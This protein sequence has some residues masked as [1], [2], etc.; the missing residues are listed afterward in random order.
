MTLGL[1]YALLGAVLGLIAGSA[2]NAFVWRLH[3]GKSWVHGR[4]QCS[5]CG[6]QLAVYDLVPVVSWVALRGRCR[7]CHKPIKDHP[8]VE[9]VSGA[10]FAVSAYVLLP[11]GPV[12]MVRLLFW[13]VALA[14]LLILAVYDAQW[15]I[16]P[17]KVVL[18]LMVVALA[19]SIVMAA[20]MR[21]PQMLVGP[22]LAGVLVSGA[23]LA[24]VMFSRGRAMGGGDIKLALAMGLLLGLKGTALAMLVAFNA[25]A[26]VGISLIVL[27][28]RGRKDQI[29][30]GPF[31]VAGTVAAFLFGQD[32][33]AWYIHVSGLG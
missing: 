28:R 16:L 29:P 6:H 32:V 12:G 7:Y 1:S 23:F 25:A 8:V 22:V 26:V 21:A 30:F 10:V 20:V 9:L 19:Y 24:L 11:V 18:P 17:D 2:I 5:E 15:M 27:R 3:E 31:L 13:L 4:S 33:S 14:L